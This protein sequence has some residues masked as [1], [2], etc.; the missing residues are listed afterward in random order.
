MRDEITHFHIR[1]IQT[2]VKLNMLPD[3]IKNAAKITTED[4]DE[5]IVPE[6]IIFHEME[7]DDPDLEL[8]S[9]LFKI[10]PRLKP[11]QTFIDDIEKVHIDT[12]TNTVEDTVKFWEHALKYANSINLAEQRK[13]SKHELMKAKGYFLIFIYQELLKKDS[14]KPYH[15]EIL[16]EYQ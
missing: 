4:D 8:H 7:G 5:S 10:L 3:W 6:V 11:D 15:Q 13:R 14:W 9:K 2:E 1:Q 16:Q 12:L